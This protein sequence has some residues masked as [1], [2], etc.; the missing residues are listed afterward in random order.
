MTTAELNKI[1]AQ[2]A[3]AQAELAV[4]Q[5]RTSEEITRLNAKLNASID[6][7]SAELNASIDKVSAEVN[8]SIDKVNKQ[9]GN[10]GRN[11]GDVAEEFFYNSLNATP[12]L[13]GIQF[14]R[15]T[16][17]L[18]VGKKGQQSEFDIVLTNGN[19]VALVEVK[20]KA[21]LND[22]LQ[23]EAQIKRYRQLCPEYKN[24]KLY[25]G[26]AGFSVPPEVVKAAHEKGLFV[27]KRKGEVLTTDAK[28]MLAF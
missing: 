4:T 12:K 20:H 18:I 25:G 24:F 26:I 19:C 21:H 14:D 9:F 7:S 11:Q 6:K 28:A 16:P 10:I 3:L 2:L 22:L 1:F 13:G 8:A 15:V 17:N 5:K 27:L 23:V